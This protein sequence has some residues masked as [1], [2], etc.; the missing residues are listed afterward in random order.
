MSGS[1]DGLGTSAMFA[2]PKDIAVDAAGTV[3]VVVSRA[4]WELGGRAK[5]AMH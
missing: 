4:R 5:H 3:A 2:Y 1:S